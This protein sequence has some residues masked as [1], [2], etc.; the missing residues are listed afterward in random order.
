MT[1]NISPRLV[2]CLALVMTF[3]PLN[4]CST[5]HASD[6]P[7]T[8]EDENRDDEH[9]SGQER[10]AN[11]DEATPLFAVITSG[12]RRSEIQHVH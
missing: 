12:E 6:I 1:S 3:A 9:D 10:G 5:K 8:D 11:A 7:L 2:T 4:A